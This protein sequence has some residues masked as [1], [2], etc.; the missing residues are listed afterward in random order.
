MKPVIEAMG[1][2]WDEYLAQMLRNY[3]WDYPYYVPVDGITPLASVGILGMPGEQDTLSGP[4]RAAL[5]KHWQEEL[6]CRTPV[7]SWSQDE[8]VDEDRCGHCP[9]CHAWQVISES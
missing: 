9:Q 7:L 3:L 4:S 6:W 5:Q 8:T 2:D 1:L